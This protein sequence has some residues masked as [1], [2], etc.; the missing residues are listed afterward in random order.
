MAAPF[1]AYSQKQSVFDMYQLYGYTPPDSVSQLATDTTMLPSMRRLFYVFHPSLEDK[2][3][4]NSHCRSDEQTIVLGCY[5]DHQG[6]YLLDVTDSRLDGV[7]QVTAAHETLHAA[8]ARLSAEE[9]QKV[10]AMTS[11]A[12]VAL[13]DQRIKDNIK[14][15]RDKDP[16]V[17]PNELHSILGT[18]VRNLPADLEFYYNKYFTNRAK[19]V[20]YSKQYEAAFTERKN[21][22][23]AYDEQL[24]SLKQQIESL[25]A[26]LSTLANDLKTLRG[27]MDSLKS[28]NQIAAYNALVPSYNSK[29]NSYNTSVDGLSQK[30]DDYN[31]IVPK[32]NAIASEESDL[33][34]AIDSRSTIPARQ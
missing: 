11:A 27:R 9:R 5:V 6:I 26:S 8:Y 30:V 31:D 16:S 7:E 2:E 10:N 34:K 20:A 24:V 12:F 33:A 19:I 13:D 4:F 1:V 25:Q 18:E 28:S 23:L 22:I 17:V 15:Y 32:R 21:Q 29:V 3:S 14:L